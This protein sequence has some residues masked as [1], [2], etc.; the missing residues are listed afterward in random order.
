VSKKTVVIIGGGFSGSVCAA[1][2][3]RQEDG[4]EI[5]VVLVN[6]GGR[7]AR[8]IA[9][10][11][12]SEVHVLNVPAGQMSAYPDDP[13]HFLRYARAQDEHVR[14]S[15]FVQ[16][17]M[18]GDYLEWLLVEAC[19]GGGARNALERREAHAVAVERCTGDGLFV[20]LE[21]GERLRADAVVLA[22]G[23]YAPADPSGAAPGVL[24]G[25]RYV[26]DPWAPG[27]L[28]AV[29]PDEPVLLLGTG[30]TMYDVALDL[31]RRGRR[32]PLYALS[33]RG[34]LPQAHRTSVPLHADL[35]PLDLD[36]GSPSARGYL[37][38]VRQ[39]VRQLGSEGIDWRHSIAAL[40][41][42]TAALWQALD[43]V[44]RRRF[45]RH[46]RPYWEVH[47]HR[48][49]P[50][51]ADAINALIA[52]GTLVVGRG[53]LLTLEATDAGIEGVFRAGST[54][55]RVRASRLINCT[56]PGSDLAS[57]RE[58]L[59]EA[60]SRSGMLRPDP[61][62]L[63]VETSAGLELLDAAGHPQPG[64]FYIGPLLRAQHWESTA[65]PELRA[66]AARL[67]EALRT[68]LA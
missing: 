66:H 37:R 47:R 39:H 14:P 29:G 16:R 32:A 34:L 35:P 54:L 63:G 21:G 45:L 27:A 2:L 18:Y 11:T 67:A 1:Q 20:T 5:R 55:L 60:L 7:M 4:P 56:G 57:Q 33:R 6:R 13:D 22:L 46:L 8:G 17:R 9:Y 24:A 10:G 40:R 19:A 64:L 65:V 25:P 42:R 3:L 53:R 48:A 12:R 58:P 68:R 61:L 44:E 15:S 50:E 62:G 52:S 36:S 59:L 49:A 23:N 26:R 31:T 38:A 43:E 30:L 28:E 51:I 41:P